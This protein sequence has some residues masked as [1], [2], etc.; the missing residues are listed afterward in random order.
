MEGPVAYVIVLLLSDKTTTNFPN[1]H[2][3]TRTGLN[4]TMEAYKQ[5]V[6]MVIFCNRLSMPV[7]LSGAIKKKCASRK[8][9]ALRSFILVTREKI[10]TRTHTRTNR[11]TWTLCA[12]VCKLGGRASRSAVIFAS[13]VLRRGRRRSRRR[14]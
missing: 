6:A 13:L 10:D 4:R 2:R 11:T 3:R 12:C 9:V 5:P 8:V 7:F 1:W 14:E